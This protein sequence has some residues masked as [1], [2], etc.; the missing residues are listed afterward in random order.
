MMTYWHTITQEETISRVKADPRRGLSAPDARARLET[1]GPNTLK[2]KPPRPLLLRLW[3]QL[4]DPMILVLLGAAALS[5]WSSGGEDWLDSAII[6]LI[7]VVN[8]IIYISQENSAQKAL[9]ALQ[10]MSAPMARVLREG[11][12]QKL[13]AAQVWSPGTSSAWRPGTLFPPTPG[14]WRLFLSKRMSRP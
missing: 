14:F 8:A 13:P 5:L 10:G 11:T 6:L 12:E 7:V 1:Y 2:G 9:E 4:K 3:D